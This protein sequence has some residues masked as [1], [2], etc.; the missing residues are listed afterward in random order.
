MLFNP[1]WASNTIIFLVMQT[2]DT[3]M[4]MTLKTGLFRKRLTITAQ[5]EY[6][7]SNIPAKTEKND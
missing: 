7:M 4:R 6:A 5:A 1:H 3:A 2:V